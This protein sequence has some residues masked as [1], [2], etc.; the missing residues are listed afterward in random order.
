MQETTSD[1]NGH[2]DEQS[3]VFFENEEKGFQY[4]LTVSEFRGNMYFG[5][6]KWIVDF[7]EDWFP[8]KEG[9]TIPYNLTT[10]S[11]L[12][13]ALTSILSTAEVLHEVAAKTK[14]LTTHQ[15]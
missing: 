2:S 11:N 3:I 13:H 7:E 8:T 14:Y 5:V 15:D 6:R 9:F 10:T 12:F 4:R 1:L